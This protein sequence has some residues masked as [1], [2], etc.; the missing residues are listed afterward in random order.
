MK[1]RLILSFVISFPYQRVQNFVWGGIFRDG[2]CGGGAKG[3]DG[4]T[5]RHAAFAIRSARLL[6]VIR[7]N[8]LRSNSVLGDG[9]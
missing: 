7:T 2:G 9:S 8:S 5:T 3:L 1:I 4:H 6:S